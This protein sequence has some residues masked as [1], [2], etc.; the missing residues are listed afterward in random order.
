MHEEKHVKGFP[1][2]IKNKGKL[3]QAEIKINNGEKNWAT[4]RK[5]AAFSQKLGI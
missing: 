3:S 5:Q 1:P 4:D 2:G